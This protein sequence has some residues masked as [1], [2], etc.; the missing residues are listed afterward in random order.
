MR[1]FTMETTAT[2]RAV[3]RRTYRADSVG[4][5]CCRAIADEDWSDAISNVG[6]AGV[7]VAALWEGADDTGQSV[8]VPDSYA[9]PDWWQGNPLEISIGL[10]KIF[11]SDSRAARP[12]A[13]HWVD[14]AFL[15]VELAEAAQARAAAR[16][17]ANASTLAEDG[18]R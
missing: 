2:I 10:L 11:A 1:E 14:R 15:A 9:E 18:R 16:A 7:Y 8:A 5:A 6:P 3:R 12:T 13:P 4:A 17:A